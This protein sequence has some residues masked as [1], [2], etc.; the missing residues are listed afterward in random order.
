MVNEPSVFEPLKFYCITI[1]IVGLPAVIT[2]SVPPSG[3]LID[4]V[5]T[6]DACKRLA[7]AGAAVVGLNCGRGPATMLPLLKEIKKVCKVIIIDCPC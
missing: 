7:D 1:S 2:L 4:G 6:A 5:S 3:V